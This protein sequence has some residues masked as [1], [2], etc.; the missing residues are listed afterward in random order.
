MIGKSM[1]R[2]FY[3][4]VGFYMGA[5]A[6]VGFW[7]GYFG[8]YVD[9]S[10]DV[11]LVI[12]AHAFV[13]MVWVGLFITQSALVGLGRTTVHRSL[14]VFGIAWGGAVIATGVLT[15]FSQAALK[16]AAGDDAGATGQIITILRDMVMF[17]LFFGI[18]IYHRTRPEIHKRWIMVAGTMLII[19]AA[20]RAN[21]SLELGRLG[22]FSLWFAPLIAGVIYDVVQTRRISWIYISGMTLMFFCTFTHRVVYALIR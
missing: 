1:S 21:R 15:G 5:I 11:P 9:N 3:V 7:P 12:H 19:A 18:A 13:F 14:G 16:E 10:L 6:L 17:T 22:F 8:A 20:A 4:G 2:V